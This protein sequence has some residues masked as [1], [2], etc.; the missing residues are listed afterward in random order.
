MPGTA[1]KRVLPVAAIAEA[2][3]GV[4]LLIVPPLVGQTPFEA[5]C[6]EESTG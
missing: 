5:E 2:A 6:K 4:A 3:T 1:L